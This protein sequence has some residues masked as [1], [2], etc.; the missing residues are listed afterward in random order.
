MSIDFRVHGI[1][2]RYHIHTLVEDLK[3]QTAFLYTNIPLFT[4]MG[5]YTVSQK[6]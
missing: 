4:R 5:Y 6:N 3:G 1:V 2:H